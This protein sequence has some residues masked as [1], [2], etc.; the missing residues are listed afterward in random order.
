[1]RKFLILIFIVSSCSIAL[2]QSLE[3]ETQFSL[4]KAI[5]PSQVKFC[6][7]HVTMEVN[8]ENPSGAHI[9]WEASSSELDKDSLIKH[10]REIFG[11][12]DKR[13]GL[14]CQVWRF[15]NQIGKPNVSVCSSTS[16]GP[17][18]DCLP[19]SNK[20]RSIVL[21]SHIADRN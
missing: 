10:Y 11:A 18:S 15:D 13:D 1:M 17:W 6:S 3:N 9:N 21:I 16:N 2:S 8:S 5:P 12:Q 19:I 14:G 20:S 4:K 7:G